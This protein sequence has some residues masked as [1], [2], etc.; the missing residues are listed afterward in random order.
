MYGYVIPVRRRL[1]EQTLAEYEADYCGLCRSLAKR[2]GFLAR[3]LVSYDM[4][5]LYALLAA[6]QEEGAQKRCFCP[7][8]PFCK[9]NCREID[10]AMEY[11]ADVS[12][13]LAAEK[14]RD[15]ALD[16]GFWKA[17]GA[18]LLLRL[19]R[20][21]EDRAKGRLPAQA[22]VLSEQMQRLHTLEEQNSASLDATADTFAVMLR[23]LVTPDMDNA[24]M[25][26]EI[27]YHT[28]RYLYLADAWD[29]LASDEKKQQYNPLR[30]RYELHDGRLSRE[31]TKNLLQTAAASMDAAIAAFDLLPCKSHAALLDNILTYGMPTVMQAVSQGKF[32]RKAN[33]RSKT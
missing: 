13:L 32:H 28:G 16:D 24:R 17:M 30:F 10:P 3:F 8:K 15:T 25:L 6:A 12:V 19:F 4:T 26:R 22:Q 20:R 9:K 27:L 5:F 2:Y 21:K 31:D 29:D 23:E 1:S 33:N 18:K 14:L 7:A 11:C